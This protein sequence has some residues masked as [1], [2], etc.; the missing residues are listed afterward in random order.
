MRLVL[1]SDVVVA[2]MR[3]P[4]GVSA[5]LVRAARA[6]RATLLASDALCLAYD[7]ACRS[8]TRLAPAGLAKADP[9]LFLDAL[10]A[11]I[12][13]VHVWFGWRPPEPSDPAGADIVLEPAINGCADM[14]ATLRRGEVAADAARFGIAV[15][16]PADALRRL[17]P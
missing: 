17:A 13:P 2:A 10:L 6:G 12:A 3:S 16:P 11:L 15:L 14:I 8:Q 5:A 9:G 4:R 7:S 1:D